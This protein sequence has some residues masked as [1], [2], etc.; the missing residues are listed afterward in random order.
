[1]TFTIPTLLQV[2]GVDDDDNECTWYA[3]AVGRIVKDGEYYYEGYYLVPSKTNS[4]LVYDETYEHIPEDS[5]M[6][7]LSVKNEGYA[8]AWE[9]MGVLMKESDDKT[10]FI[11]VGEPLFEFSE[12]LGVSTVYE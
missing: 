4:H 8:L 7:K 6:A 3:E 12:P 9:K 11:K 2:R 10:Y 5:V 1:M